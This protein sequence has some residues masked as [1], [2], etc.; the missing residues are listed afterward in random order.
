MQ[1]A[2][3]LGVVGMLSGCGEDGVGTITCMACDAVVVF[4]RRDF[5]AHRRLKAER[6]ARTPMFGDV[7]SPCAEKI[8]WREA[9]LE[10][11]TAIAAHCADAHS[12]VPA[13]WHR[14][15]KACHD[16]WKSREQCVVCAR[17]GASQG[18]A[19]NMYGMELRWRALHRVICDAER[20]EYSCGCTCCGPCVRPVDVTHRKSVSRMSL[21][22]WD[23]YEAVLVWP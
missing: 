10:V 5:D 14:Q 20:H 11:E 23:A 4:D 17:C 9:E 16:G 8:A 7:P 18:F 12:D 2:H 1:D 13:D 19:G 22:P 6:R 3:S 21:T 15:W